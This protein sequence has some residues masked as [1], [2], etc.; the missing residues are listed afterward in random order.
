MKHQFRQPSDGKGQPVPTDHKQWVLLTGWVG[1][2]CCTGPG[3]GFGNTCSHPRNPPDHPMEVSNEI[4]P[5]PRKVRNLKQRPP[6]PGVP[7]PRGEGWPWDPWAAPLFPTSPRPLHL[8]G[9]E[10]KKTFRSS[11][12]RNLAGP[13]D[14]SRPPASQSRRTCV[15]LPAMLTSLK[16]A[17]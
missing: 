16:L 8:L 9:K 14:T 15:L 4:P 1:L 5:N 3:T 2:T 11:H 17:L 7:S 12:T 10:Q 13:E 6:S